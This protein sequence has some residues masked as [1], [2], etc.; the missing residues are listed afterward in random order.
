[1]PYH[2][3]FML[4]SLRSLGDSSPEGVPSCWL[5]RGGGRGALVCGVRATATWLA[6]IITLDG[7]RALHS[8]R[9]VF[10]PLHVELGFFSKASLPTP[11][12]YPMRC[13]TD[14]T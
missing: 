6:V 10:W 7:S 12:S 11:P 1:M 4:L 8:I 14:P 5:G 13:K 3:F 9:N 2:F